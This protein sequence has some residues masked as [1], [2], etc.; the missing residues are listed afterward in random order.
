MKSNKLLFCA[1]YWLVFPVRIPQYKQTRNVQK[2]SEYKSIAMMKSIVIKKAS[3]YPTAIECHH[4]LHVTAVVDTIL[5][6]HETSV[7]LV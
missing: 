2:M 3:T 5:F 1:G 6:S 7:R 4:L